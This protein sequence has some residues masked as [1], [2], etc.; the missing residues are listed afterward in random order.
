MIALILSRPCSNADPIPPVPTLKP[1]EKERIRQS[2]TTPRV[3]DNQDRKAQKRPE[4]LLKT[5]STLVVCPVSLIYQWRDEILS[6]TSPALNVVL[7]HGPL[8]DVYP[9]GLASADGV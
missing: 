7:Y 5:K 4:T 2:Y 1:F 3:L 8:R 9:A 6:K